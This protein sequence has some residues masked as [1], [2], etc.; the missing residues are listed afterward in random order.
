MKKYIC[1]LV[2]FSCFLVSS[3]QTVVLQ[4]D[5]EQATYNVVASGATYNWSI[6]TRLHYSGIK[7][8]SNIVSLNDTAYLTTVP[9]TTVG[10]TSVLLRFSHICKIELLDAGE[11]EVSV[12]NGPWIKLTGDHYINP[13]N[14]QFENNG[15][16]FNTNTY[17][18]NWQPAI[19]GVMPT[20]S[21][22]KNEIFNISA[23]AANSSNVRI[24]FLL[25]DGNSNG[26]STCHGWY[27][28]NISVTASADEIIPPKI[29]VIPVI[30]QDTVF[31]TGPFDIYAH[32][33]DSSGI[34]TAYIV[35]K[36]NNGTE[37]VEPM[38][39]ISD[40]TYKGTIPSYTYTNKI[41]YHVR[42]FDNSTAHVQA[43]GLSFWFYIKK[44][45]PLV[46]IGNGTTQQAWPYATLYEDA[47]TQLI[48][49][50]NEITAADG[51]A[52]PITSIAF[53][54]ASA[55]A[56]TMN[57]F[58][59]KMQHTSLSNLS[60]F[61]NT[62]WATVYSG[63]Y[64][65]TNTGWQTIT[66]Q[67]PFNWDGNSNLLIDI[68][69]DNTFTSSNSQV[70]CTPASGKT[71][72]QYVNGS[73]GC[74]LGGGSVQ[75]NRPN[76]QLHLPTF[77]YTADAGINQ[78]ISPAGTI[79]S[80]VNNPVYIRIKNYADDTL[81]KVK[82]A[83]QLDGISQAIFH[84]T[85]QLAEDVI[86]GV[87]SIGDINVLPGS[88]TIKVWTEL[89]NDNADQFH[90]N[91]TLNVNFYAC[92]SYLNGTYTIG[93]GCNYADFNSALAS[94]N[95]CGING[96]VIFNVLPGI[97]NEQINI[98]EIPGA[99][100][101]HTITFQSAS[102]NYNDVTLAYSASGTANNFVVNLNGA[103]YIHFK[104]LTIQAN[105]NVYSNVI[106]Y[107]N[108]ATYNSFIGNRL[109]GTASNTTTI[110]KAVI[111]SPSGALTCD[112]VMLFEENIIENG[113]YGIYCY[114]QGSAINQL[115]NKTIIKNNQFINQY[116]SG[117][118]LYYQNAPEVTQNTFSTNN[119]YTTFYSI[120][121]GYCDNQLKIL[122]NKISQSNGG[123]GIYLSY[124]D[125]AY[126]KEGL[127]ANNM[128]SIS[129]INSTYGIYPYYCSNQ[130]I[131]YNS[132]NIYSNNSTACAFY[133]S[134]S[135]S[136]IN[137]YLKNNIFAY[138]GT[139]LS[140]LA[141]YIAN[142]AG[143]ASM[144]YNDLY[145]SGTNLGY[146]TAMQPNLAAWKTVSSKDSNSVSVNPYFISPADLHTYSSQINDHAISVAGVSDDI[147]G[148]LRDAVTP[149]IG[150]SEFD[151]PEKNI[152]ILYVIEPV[153][154]CGA[155]SP[156]NVVIR[157]K[158]F[159]STHITSADVY[160]AINGGTAIHETMT[161]SLLP[162][163]EY[164]YTFTQQADLTAPG[165]YSF[166]FWVN[167]SGDTIPL[168]DTISNYIVY[169][170]YD[171]NS[172]YFT[173]GF[174]ASENFSDWLVVD[175]NG[176]NYGWTIPYTSASDAHT[177]S[178]SARLYNA[179]NAGNDW[180]FSRCFT[181][182]AGATYKIEFWYRAY[183]SSY[184]QTIDLKAGNTA[185][186][187]AM[188]SNLLTLTSFN[189]TS[190][191]KATAY[192]IPANSGSYYFGWWG[193]SVA[194]SYYAFVDDINISLVPLQEAALLSVTAPISGCGLT[195]AETVSILIKN[196]G[197]NEIN[198]NYNASYTFNNGT[199]VTE[200]LTSSIAPNDTLSFSF[201]QTVD[202]HVVANDSIF[203]LKVWVSLL[204]D[205]Y[206]FNDTINSPI[207]SSH[208]PAD[209]LTIS[210]T[211]AYGEPATLIASS[212]D[213]I[214]WFDVP[215]GGN[216]IFSGDTL[217][218]PP[219]FVNTVYYA[220]S[221]T[222]GGTNSW[223]FDSGL[224]GWTVQNPCSST[225]EWS[226]NSDGGNG[227][228]Y[229]SNPAATSSQLIT[230]PSVI[231]A[232]AETVS[233]SFTHRY[234]TE[235]CCDEGYVAYRLDNGPWTQ[236]FPTTNTY[237]TSTHSVDM[238]PLNS[239]T[240]N[241]KSCFYGAQSAY[242]TS[243]GSINTTGATNIQL[244][245]VYT[246]DLSV[247][248]DGW[249]INDVVLSGGMGGC[250]SNRIPDTAYV[251][252][253]PFEASLTD[254]NSPVSSCAGSFENI[255]IRIRNNG[256]NTINGN[257]TA[258]YKVNSGPVV[259]EAILDVIV[260]G[261]TIS[262]TFS[263]PFT[264][265][266]SQSY[267]D[268]AFQIITYIELS[269]DTYT[270]NDTLSKTVD[271]LYTPPNPVTTNIF[272]PYG[273]SGT[274]NIIS[275]DSLYWFDVPV[276]GTE[277]AQG[278]SY[279]TPVL[280]GTTF[281]YVESRSG[282]PD[283]KLTEITHFSTGTGY[284]NPYPAWCTGAD[285]IEISN[286]GT[287]P[288]NLGNYTMNI[289]GVGNRSYVIPDITLEAGEILVLCAGTGIDDPANK[290]YNMGGG[291][292][293]IQSTS[294]SGFA[295]KT[296][297][298]EVVDAVA[299]NGYIFTISDGVSAGDWSGNIN[300]MS[301]YAGT[302]RM[303]SDNNISGDWIISSAIVP[304]TIG[305]LNPNLSVSYNGSG[306]ASARVPDTAY[307][308]GVPPCDMSVLDIY[309]PESAIELGSAEIITVK[310]KNY[311]T[312]TAVNIPITYNINETTIIND[313]IPGP[314][315][316]NDTT[317]FSFAV[318]ADL[319][320]YGTYQIKV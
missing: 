6:N 301:G 126:D 284:T 30:I 38:I 51:V 115:E 214:Y 39:W 256:L 297:N 61:V 43:D 279:T 291:N 220:Q 281:Y 249:Y 160:Y 93:A 37:M 247:G 72:T 233:L 311:G 263:T 82:I 156:G 320:A 50:S 312:Q 104:N 121:C 232:G 157:L 262:F 94:L 253:L 87:F 316:Q 276:G 62:G 33:T 148:N 99:S 223:T 309:S 179:N 195:S 3:A 42:A 219:L 58:N 299:S 280:F 174:E 40:S 294:L 198:G 17:P 14:S 31:N 18:L 114:G 213:F 92:S 113:S 218:T 132:V 190:Y 57:N 251:E 107:S 66:L 64:T 277:I 1:L 167:L 202:A 26:S 171:F 246:T 158:N 89:P 169:S 106:K 165:N 289:Y 188:V 243:S 130:K 83:W 85:G 150:A 194:S 221:I 152:G 216:V 271:L 182:N 206:S 244:A 111:I 288:I 228:L 5:F 224:E 149:D 109:L 53:N 59:I 11:I 7:C 164:N 173:I 304:Q 270:L 101:L 88:H 178:N 193:H 285:L 201:T 84:W 269:G 266:L 172:G 95:N 267:Q 187:G 112:S 65:V 151:V 19:N 4:E 23:I 140:G 91:D 12:N 298:G 13:G 250:T 162:E 170:G 98:P 215:T 222:Q 118:Y 137:H 60:G 141:V 147:D 49:A 41:D 36:L 10:Y 257:F 230:S 307:V 145:S 127:I 231:V 76:I 55:S 136:N 29:T 319:S 96:Q 177:G 260:P 242:I 155:T 9:F 138:T 90:S 254:I 135:T 252:L 80:G 210:D 181:L 240:S 189:N 313:T 142:T 300:G 117:I 123:Y 161:Y 8:D 192:F 292:D 146:W 239:C 203:P 75:T 282:T 86:S 235:S 77:T 293:I 275:T 278:N 255:S 73:S 308:T 176:D 22:W 35:Y 46:E 196:T 286:L 209:P 208:I 185:T 217:I 153:N 45:I 183:N 184:P 97:Y 295:L 24:R 48:Y 134:G 34:D 52:G 144:N 211:T 108:N 28:D 205:P 124:C 163:A 129:G 315:A 237:S 283:V 154:S 248:S 105:G 139:N 227:T 207:A 81:T 168:N 78:I 116:Y 303:I 21:W 25:R 70:Y 44:I 110:D 27:I 32:I 69:Y 119:T 175:V 236:F 131:Y 199:P 234:Q 290:Y 241:S 317:I 186:P 133:L 67:T 310:V 54:V 56:I 225:V 16:K 287:S 261:D 68:C 125:G 274:F 259:S 180:L 302:I 100:S 63:T 318:P 143:V 103:D 74:T 306:C 204:N 197:T 314:I 166:K 191:Q 102:G 305:T 128:I 200:V 159:G 258:H 226:W 79:L 273:T 20:Q 120:Y 212:S 229:A 296:P 2:M 265:G 122:K 71:W 264:T 245:F 15:N 272:V 238:D 47:R 268:S